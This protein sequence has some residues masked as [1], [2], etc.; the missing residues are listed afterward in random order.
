V[1][2]QPI[3][4]VPL[5]QR[6]SGEER[7]LLISRLKRRHVEPGELIIAE[8]HTA[9]NLFIIAAGWVKLE[10][11]RATLANLGAGSLLG[12]IDML[13]RRPYSMTARSAAATQLLVLSHNDLQELIN[14]R[15]SIGLKFSAS[16][17]VRIAFLEKYLVQQRLRNI[18]LLSALS[19]E[20]LRAIAQRLDFRAI[21]RG[22]VVIEAGADG[23]A[24]F[25]IEEGQVRLITRS[26]DGESFEDLENGAIFG[27][28]SLLTGKAYAS[29]A[30]VIADG[31]LWVL[32][33]EGYQ[34]LLRQHPAVKLALSRALAEALSEKDQSDAAERMR[35]LQLFA[36][37]PSD[38]L[39]ALAARLVL[40]HFPADEV[41][42]T[43]G[44]PGDAMYIVESGEVRL[45]NGLTSDAQL[46]ERMRAGDSFGDMALLTGRTRSDYARA[47]T[48]TT[49]WV[50]YKNDFD[51]VMVQ[52]PSVSVS[53]GRALTERLT[54]RESDLVIRHL[55]RMDLLSSLAT[56]E[57]KDVSTRVRGIR[58]RPGEMICF[59]GEPAQALFM[60]A[61]GQAKRMFTDM[62]GES[63]ADIL[64]VGAA[65]GEKDLVQNRPY[66]MT[67][68]AL[69]DTEVWTITK[70]DFLSLMEKY[71]T[72]ALTVTRLMAD[73]PARPQSFQPP[74]GG[75]PMPP[76]QNIPQAP[77]IQRPPSGARPIQTRIEM[78][79][80]PKPRRMPCSACARQSKK[81]LAVRNWLALS[82]AT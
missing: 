79:A 65:F 75:S 12:E 35:N 70:V 51:D 69:T 10:G 3:D 26:H 58:F 16:I 25:F 45:T 27:H 53:L 63:S 82:S 57:L 49:I 24:A 73:Q 11:G 78:P 13:M 30:R 59:A 4:T 42:Y 14:E 68:Q 33:R 6:L 46:I 34:S 9:E 56:S 29:T 40:R 15:P 64:D 28:T 17:G 5:F 19:E 67:V 62:Y 36:D 77:R 43:S 48:D 18:E 60:I 7:Q 38:A 39:S 66:S 52:Y 8:G 55:R 1:I 61:G 50:L 37:V 20:D 74:R 22:D 44:T 31:T 72:L 23:D 21:S 80:T 71:P 47:A 2:P 32:P 54:T 81:P 41:I 76:H